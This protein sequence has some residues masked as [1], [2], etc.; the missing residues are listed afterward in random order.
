[1]DSGAVPGTSPAI[2]WTDA[3]YSLISYAPPFNASDI[4]S[5]DAVS[6]LFFAGFSASVYEET[7]SIFTPEG[8]HHE[9]FDQFGLFHASADLQV[10]P[11]VPGHAPYEQYLLSITRLGTLNTWL[12]EEV[13][14]ATRYCNDLPRLEP[15]PSGPGGVNRENNMVDPERWDKWMTLLDFVWVHG[16]PMTMGDYALAVA[17]DNA[18]TVLNPDQA[19]SDH[20]GIGDVV[21]GAVLEAEDVELERAVEGALAATLSNHGVGISGQ[22]VR[23]YF[24]ADGDGVSET[25]VGTTDSD[26]FAS[27]A[28]LSTRPFGTVT[29]YS[30]YWDGIVVTASDEGTV[31]IAGTCP[32]LADLT[33][34]C[35]VDIQD[36]QTFAAQWLASGDPGDCSWTADLH[37]AD[38]KVDLRDLAILAFEWLQGL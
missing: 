6:R 3:A 18:P 24:D 29:T 35:R 27:V 15:C 13:E 23:F 1:M 8:S 30:A 14:W 16:Q 4:P 34:D 26:G 7:S 38:C 2:D 19:D 25:Y 9:T 11:E 28:V 36:L 21:D 31:S 12:I 20:N 32:L 10:N 17:L 5:R 37:G 22:K 33:G